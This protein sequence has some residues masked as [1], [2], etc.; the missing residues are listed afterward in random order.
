[1][2][3]TAQMFGHDSSA[4]QTV[5][6][7]AP[8]VAPHIQAAHYAYHAQEPMKKAMQRVGDQAQDE[9]VDRSGVAGSVGSFIHNN[10]NWMTNRNP[11][12]NYGYHYLR[13]ALACVP[14]GLMC[15]LVFAGNSHIKK[16]GSLTP[17]VGEINKGWAAWTQ[18]PLFDFVAQSAMIG[19]A[20]TLYRTTSFAGRRFYERVFNAEN[21]EQRT[22]DELKAAPVNFIDDWRQNFDIQSHSVPWAALSL[23][24]VAVLGKQ[25]SSLPQLVE[26]AKHFKKIEPTF[27][28]LKKPLFSLTKPEIINW[29]G[30]NTVAYSIFFEIADQLGKRRRERAGIADPTK[31]INDID[32]SKIEPGKVQEILDQPKTYGFFTDDS[33]AGRWIFRRML[34]V[35]AGVGSYVLMKPKMMEVSSNWVGLNKGL[36]EAQAIA[37]SRGVDVPGA[38]ASMSGK[39]NLWQNSFVEGMGTALFANYTFVKDPWERAYDRFF[40]K[41]ERK[42][43][44]EFYK[45]KDELDKEGVELRVELRKKAPQ[46]EATDKYALPTVPAAPLEAKIQTPAQIEGV[47][48]AA[49]QELVK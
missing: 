24:G 3:H 36:E 18:H 5:R 4:A 47:A 39:G 31:N 46:P 6:A 34:P 1:M 12:G 21:A 23:G 10:K 19:T 30:I 40:D 43:N 35:A 33:G 44:P 13:S 20:F 49:T 37:R 2:A 17:E 9:A 8:S 22:I 41:L 29:V 15:G 7:G 45:R 16:L 48:K 32:M 14:Y 26:A 25:A 42:A 27:G 11:V 38:I 28:V